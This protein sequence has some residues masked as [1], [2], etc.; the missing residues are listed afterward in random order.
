MFELQAGD[1]PKQTLLF[2]PLRCLLS[3]IYSHF[4]PVRLAAAPSLRLL[5]AAQRTLDVASGGLA[6]RYK[7]LC[8]YKITDSFLIQWAM[9]K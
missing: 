1:F 7:D 4:N 9:G 2:L 6:E 3:L 5:A 8:F